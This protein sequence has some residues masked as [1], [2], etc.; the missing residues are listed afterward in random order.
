LFLTGARF[1]AARARELGL[2]HRIAPAASLDEVVD[3]YLREIL[4]SAPSALAA[5]KGLIKEIHGSRPA[6]VIGVTTLRIAEQ[7][8]SVEGQEGMRAFLEK[9][10]PKWVR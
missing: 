10:K 4:T 2:V 1:D 5:A 3:G 7:R 8:V 9:R 6:E